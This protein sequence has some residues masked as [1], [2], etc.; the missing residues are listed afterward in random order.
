MCA[1][2]LHTIGRLVRVLKVH[3]ATNLFLFQSDSFSAADSLLPLSLSCLGLALHRRL[4]PHCLLLLGSPAEEEEAKHRTRGVE[5]VVDG[6]LLWFAGFV[7][8]S[9]FQSFVFIQ[10]AAAAAV[11]LCGA[12]VIRYELLFSRSGPQK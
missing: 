11:V 2:P 6:V 7:M 10:R 9:L 3:V 5:K 4:P 8:I 1:S 12:S